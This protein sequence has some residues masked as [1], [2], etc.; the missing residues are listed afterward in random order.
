VPEG[1]SYCIGC[2]SEEQNQFYIY[3]NNFNQANKF[4][5]DKLMEQSEQLR[6]TNLDNFKQAADI[7]EQKQFEEKKG[8]ETQTRMTK[9]LD[10][11]KVVK[12]E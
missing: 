6:K 2:L 4:K 3:L 7:Y 11:D 8:S 9:M 10:F 12:I 1:I 5:L